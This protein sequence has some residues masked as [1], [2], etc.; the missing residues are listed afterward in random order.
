MQKKY[1]RGEKIIVEE[2]VERKNHQIAGDAFIVDG[3]I[4][5]FGIANEHFDEECNP[6]VPIGESFPV[7][8]S[9]TEIQAARNE[10]QRAVTELG[11]KNGAI[12]LDFMFT[13]TG[14]IFIIELGPRNGGNLITDA[15]K[16]SSGIDL[17]E[18]TIKAA[19]GEDL[20]SL[21]EVPSK[22]YSS[23][24]IWHSCYDGIFESIN[25]CDELQSKIVKSTIF[26]NKGDNIYRFDNGGF[27]IGAAIL[28]FDSEDEML[29]MMDHMNKFY[30]IKLR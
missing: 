25:I 19:L 20:S 28:E 10:I 2:F 15:I 11:I 3:K 21:Q 29:Y 9:E 4:V 14:E 12:N 27:G 24:Y 1:A 13:K 17:A 26:V 5:V 7:E 22:K 16:Y 6:L 30:E 18:Y 23:S 8:L